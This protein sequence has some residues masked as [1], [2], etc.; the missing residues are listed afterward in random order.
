MEM[1][2]IAFLLIQPRDSRS[3]AAMNGAIPALLGWLLWAS[4]AEVQAQLTF[5]TNNG[6]ITIT[7]YT[8]S[9]GAVTIPSTTNGYR[10]ASIATDAFL[11]KTT[12]TNI[13][14]GTNVTSIGYQAFGYC[15]GLTSITIP[16]SVTNIGQYAFEPCASLA[17]VTLPNHLAV[18]PEE[19]FGECG[20]LTSITI[21]KSVT[22]I[23]SAAFDN[24]G[25]L[26]AVYFQGNAPTPGANVFFG[27]NAGEA[28][29]Y[30]LAGTTG[31]ST[32]YGGLPTV[33]LNPPPQIADIGLQDAEFGFTVNGA[34]NQVLVVEACTDLANPNWQPLQTNTLIGTA[35]NFTDSQSRNYSCRFYRV[36]SVPQ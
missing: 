20:S 10:I 19:M 34:S 15:S 3:I 32:L 31:W 18:I 30:Y 17:S 13:T 25:R 26:T 5:T 24:C 33:E 12:L 27:V 9:G 8:G 11:G 36:E 1:K 14:I 6:A 4:P 28:K 35:F 21:P 2:T 23:Q 16:N 22:N 29:V 7:D